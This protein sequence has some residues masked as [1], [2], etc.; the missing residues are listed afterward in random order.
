MKIGVIN[1]SIRSGRTSEAVTSWV[2]DNIGGREHD[3]EL[4][5]LKDFDLPMYSGA[6]LPMRMDKQYDSPEVTRWSQAIDACDAFILITPEYNH[7]VPAAMKNAVD[8][9]G[10][11]WV[12][13]PI[14]FVGYGPMGAIR[15]IEHW[16]QI[17]ANFHMHDI[18]EQL[19]FVAGMEM[20]DG[21]TPM[22]FRKK[23]LDTMLDR[24][25]AMTQQLAK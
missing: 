7:S 2:M 6:G 16:R 11:E 15:A 19:G 9:I 25:E 14:A 13:K 21:F 24:L 8:S 1:G 22:D 3:Y 20:R 17:M 4:I 12:G 5:D 10:P 18:R 23:E